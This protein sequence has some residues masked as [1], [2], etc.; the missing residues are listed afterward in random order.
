LGGDAKLILHHKIIIIISLLD[1]Y[2]DDENNPVSISGKECYFFSTQRIRNSKW[3]QE[4]SSY[5]SEGM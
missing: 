5:F 1:I 4:S 2:S 3:L